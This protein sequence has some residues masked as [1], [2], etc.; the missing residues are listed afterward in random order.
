[1][2]FGQF[3]RRGFITLLGGAVA[4]PLAARAQHPRQLP[5]GTRRHE[6]GSRRSGGTRTG[7]PRRARVRFVTDQRKGTRLGGGAVQ[8][9]DSIVDEGGGH[10][11][12]SALID[13][14]GVK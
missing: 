12:M 6:P 13:L 7:R 2:Q 10:A 5:S 8:E 11:G 4:W 1:M 9:H 3:K 14:V